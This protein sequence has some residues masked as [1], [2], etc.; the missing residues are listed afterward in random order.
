M[1]RAC[2]LPKSTLHPRKCIKQQIVFS[3]LTIQI[4]IE[5]TNMEL[6]QSNS[7]NSKGQI[8]IYIGPKVDEANDLWTKIERQRPDGQ[9]NAS[10]KLI[11]GPKS[12]G[13]KSFGQ[14][15]HWTK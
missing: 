8:I 3:H 5:Y 2:H 15:L 9:K 11:H 12:D 10:Y 6:K 1:M 7:K 14:N 13:Q 4:V